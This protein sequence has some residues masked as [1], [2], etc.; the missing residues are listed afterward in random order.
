MHDQ[1]EEEMKKI[2]YLLS[3]LICFSACHSKTSEQ[4][5]QAPYFSEG[6]AELK[7]YAMDFQDVQEEA[8]LAVEVLVLKEKEDTPIVTENE[9]TGYGVTK[10]PVKII[11]IL[12]GDFDFAV[13]DEIYVWE[14]YFLR[15]TQ[16][17]KEYYSTLGGYRPM[18]IGE[19][20]FLFLKENKKE[21]YKDGFSIVGAYQGKFAVKDLKQEISAS[22]D[23]ATNSEKEQLDIEFGEDDRE[24][25]LKLLEQARE[26]LKDYLKEE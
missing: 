18:I 25:Y 23:S 20:Y 17:G 3:V 4:S 2:L 13:D 7:F 14:N 21:P 22:P 9:T 24:R 5:Q 16:N 1:K 10:T 26:S 11:A 19:K 12:K 15:K 6:N 8:D